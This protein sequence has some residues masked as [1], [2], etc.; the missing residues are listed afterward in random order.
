MCTSEKIETI[1]GKVHS[2]EAIQNELVVFWWKTL[3]YAEN[4]HLKTGKIVL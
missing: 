3:S 1:R 2:D 4:R